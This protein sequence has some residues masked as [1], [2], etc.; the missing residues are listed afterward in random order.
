MLSIGN[1]L[2]YFTPGNLQQKIG[3][4]SVVIISNEIDSGVRK[5]LFGHIDYAYITTV[6]LF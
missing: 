3:V 2:K 1:H 4:H 6:H 5:V